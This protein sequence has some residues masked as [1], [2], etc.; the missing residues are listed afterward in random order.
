MYDDEL[1][2]MANRMRLG[3]SQGGFEMRMSQVRPAPRT[4]GGDGEDSSYLL[5]L[6][7]GG[8]VLANAV[9]N[10]S[11]PPFLALVDSPPSSR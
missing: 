6:A 4:R 10:H 9:A 2:R 7:L 1:S 11:T 8:L 5:M 3:D